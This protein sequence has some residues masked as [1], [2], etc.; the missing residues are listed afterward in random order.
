MASRSPLATMLWTITALAAIDLSFLAVREV[1]AL[2]QL[3]P[4]SIVRYIEYGRSVPSKVGADIRSHGDLI[5]RDA[6]F[7]VQ[8]PQAVT[9]QGRYPPRG[10]DRPCAAFYGM[11]FSNRIAR[12]IEAGGAYDVRLVAG[13]GTP[14]N[15]SWAAYLAD[16]SRS[17]CRDIVVWTIMTTEAWALGSTTMLVHGFDSAKTYSMPGIT[18]TEG[19]LELRWPAVSDPD[20]FLRMASSGDWDRLTDVLAQEEPIFLPVAWRA[21]WADRSSLLGF[22]RRGLAVNASLDTKAAMTGSSE[23]LET[24]GILDALA[25]MGA[26][27]VETARR[28][29]SVPVVL[30]IRNRDD[31]VDLASLLCRRDATLPLFS[32]GTIV[33][34]ANS[35]QFVSDGHYRSELDAA[36]ADGLVQAIETDTVGCEA[37]VRP[38]R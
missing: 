20:A 37:T 28:D 22:V 3:V 10:G 36:L 18:E 35:D 30:V 8:N 15:W 34:P 9:T 13:P 1:E 5:G 33:N 26:R 29:G 4:P 38:A 12:A 31:A 16:R 21:R 32:T 2:R 17:D 6:W 19:D 14:P 11:S 23:A 7:V 25:L 24:S 27:F